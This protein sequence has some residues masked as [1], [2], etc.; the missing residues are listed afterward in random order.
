M[1]TNSSS[2]ILLSLARTILV[3]VVA[4]IVVVAPPVAKAD[5]SPEQCR[6]ERNKLVNDCRPV[7]LQ[8][9]NPSADCCQQVRVI[10]VECICPF[11]TPKFANLINAARTV[12]QIRGCG[13]NLPHNFKCGSEYY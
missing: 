1:R 9:Q 4:V 3:V 5:T 7:V 13:R 12:K 11:V 10:H 8:G 2:V 6:E